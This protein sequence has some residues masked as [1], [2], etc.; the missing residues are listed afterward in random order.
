MIENNKMF[1]FINEEIWQM[2][3]AKNIKEDKQIAKYHSTNSSTFL[4]LKLRII[5]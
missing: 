5:H 2:D 1:C 4:K 3:Y